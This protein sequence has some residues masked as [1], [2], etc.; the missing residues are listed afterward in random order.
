MTQDLADSIVKAAN[1]ID[2]REKKQREYG[3]V[4]YSPKAYG[5]KP[6]TLIIPPDNLRVVFD[7]MANVVQFLVDRDWNVDPLIYTWFNRELSQEMVIYRS[8]KTRRL[9]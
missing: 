5:D 8:K 6:W 2:A 9:S 7:T 1:D 3:T 4:I